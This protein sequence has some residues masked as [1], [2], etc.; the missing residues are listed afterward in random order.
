VLPNPEA[1]RIAI[2]SDPLVQRG[3]AERVVH[4]I[5]EAFP[6]SPIFAI[7][8]S[9]KNGPAALKERIVGSWLNRIP[10]ASERH[11]LMLPF[12]RGAIESFDLREF[13]VIVSSHHTVAKGLLRRAGQSHVCYCHT[14]MRALWE[15]TSEELETLWPILRPVAASVF[16]DM[17]SWDVITSNRVDR[18]LA[19][20]RTTQ[21]RIA[22][23]YRRESQV[24]N[25]PIDTDR[26]VIGSGSEDYYLVASRTVPYK[27]VDVA[28]A[29]AER[30]GRKLLL[31]GQRPKNIPPKSKNIEYLGHVS[32]EDL[33]GLMQG[34]KA[35][36]FPQFE[37][38]GMT[39]PEIN[40]CGRPAVAFGAG[41]ALETVIDGVTGILV[42]EQSV[43]SFVE[44]MLRLESSEFVP[45]KLRNHALQYGKAHFIAEIRRHVIEE[46]N[47]SV[48]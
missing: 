37:D 16:S 27:R 46:A 21:R 36:I 18:F 26:F 32:D 41:G 15:R 48:V 4:A 7:M 23:H 1:L 39:I 45:S 38:F 13:D 19:N 12:Y 2:V 34:A 6:S 40:A 25:P 33:V 31:V 14:V 42:P 28:I 29:A 30:L 17:R 35:L 47:L 24:L 3:G 22:R 9:E 8:Y 44:G 10:G 11:R 43:D 20:S 5:A